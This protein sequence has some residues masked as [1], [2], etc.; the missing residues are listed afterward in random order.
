M[1]K[2]V[3]WL[4][5]LLASGCT[6]QVYESNLPIGHPAIHYFEGSLDDPVTRLALRVKSGEVKLD[7]RDGLGYLPSLLDHL[8]ISVDSQ[9][10]VF[11]KTSFQAGKISPRNPRAIY[12]GDD[13]AAGFV[14]GS[15]QLELAGLDSR[16][17]VI[18]YSF[19]T[20]KSGRPMFVR[21][22]VCL[23][24]HQG[25]ATMGVPGIYV[26]SVYPSSSGFPSPIGAIVTDHRTP[27]E[28]RW[29]GW[30]VSGTVPAQHRGNAVAHNPDEPEALQ[31]DPAESLTDLN[32]KF[33]TGGYLSP[34]SDV[35]ALMTFEHQTQ[36]T[37]LFTEVGWEARVAE[38]DAKTAE[39][40][41]VNLDGRVE[42]VVDYM[43]FVN[44]ALLKGSVKGVSDFA[45]TF[46]RRGPHDRQG[47]SLRDFDLQ[48]RLF[49]YPLSY[50][51]YSKAFDALPAIVKDRIYRRLYDILTGSGGGG[52]LAELSQAERRAIVEI[53]R[54]TK[55]NLPSYWQVPAE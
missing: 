27:L 40:A 1:L 25:P 35:V 32:Q 21:D 15:Q 17:G 53:L 39:F 50:M 26:S 51:I 34:V 31:R 14:R 8:A 24:C 49:R 22:A 2:S 28:D 3:R 23:Q 43:L 37:N 12:F 55:P 42:Q 47:R 5:I 44:E 45:R 33:D 41:R 36:M 18:F 54:D 29:G 6:A 48:T 9:A 13:A 16:Q 11:S 30:F 52:G 19:D 10:L 4:P 20:D 7:F 38:H 46:P